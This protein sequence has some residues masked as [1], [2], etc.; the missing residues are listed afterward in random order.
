MDMALSDLEKKIN[1][2]VAVVNQLRSENRLLRQQIATRT[3]ENKRLTEKIEAAMA[4]LDAL[5]QQLPEN[6]T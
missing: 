5:L 6:E 4:R 2:L 3:N 1:Q